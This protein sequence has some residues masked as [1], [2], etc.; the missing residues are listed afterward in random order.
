MLEMEGKSSRHDLRG[1]EI[2]YQD[3]D[4]FLSQKYTYAVVTVA[5][6]QQIQHLKE[7]LVDE[8]FKVIY[9]KTS[10]AELRIVAGTAHDKQ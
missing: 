4:D 1:G 10:L 8:G 3:D 9:Q 5:T 6:P 7:L 2:V